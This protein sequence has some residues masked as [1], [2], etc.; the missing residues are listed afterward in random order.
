MA[1]DSSFSKASSFLMANDP[2][3]SSLVLESPVV[4]TQHS[5]DSFMAELLIFI[6]KPPDKNHWA[7]FIRS[8]IDRNIGAVTHATGSV[9]KGFELE[10][11]RHYKFNE[12]GSGSLPI[13]IL[14]QWIDAKNIDEEA[15]LN[16]REYKLDYKP[17][18]K[19]EMSAYKVAPPGKHEYINNS[20]VSLHRSLF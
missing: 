18:C 5:P 3:I 10:I 11:K 7:F 16:N 20:S 12:F 17:V 1:S 4:E 15:M 14:L 9:D 6:N 13:R 2:P 19:F 8:H